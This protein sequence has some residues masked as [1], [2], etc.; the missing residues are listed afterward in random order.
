MNVLEFNG[1]QFNGENI[2]DI[3]YRNQKV[4]ECTFSSLEMKNCD[5][6]GTQFLETLFEQVTISGSDF[7]NCT[8]ASDQMEYDGNKFMDCSMKQAVIKYLSVRYGIFC[9]CN[10][11]GMS[12]NLGGFNECI[13]EKN[14]MKGF[15][16]DEGVFDC[17]KMI[18]NDARGANLAHGDFSYIEEMQDNDFS[19]S[20]LNAFNWYHCVCKSDNYSD[21]SMIH[22]TN[23]KTVFT[24][25][26]FKN[27]RIEKSYFTNVTFV[28]CEMDNAQLSGLEFEKCVFR[29]MDF[30]KFTYDRLQFKKCTFENV[31][32]TQEQ[33]RNFTCDPKIQAGHDYGKLFGKFLGCRWLEN[34][35][36]EDNTLEM[37]DNPDFVWAE[38]KD[39]AEEKIKSLKL[40]LLLLD[41]KDEMK[42]RVEELCPEILDE[43]IEKQQ[44]EFI[45]KKYIPKIREKVEKAVAGNALTEQTVPHI[46]GIVEELFI[47][48]FYSAY[49]KSDFYGA[50]LEVL[51][52]GHLPCGVRGKKQKMKI[53][54]Y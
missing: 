5:F 42:Y 9:G 49:F 35:G 14:N 24:N 11:E 23:E 51:L 46:T 22:T 21:C 37:L 33:E 41:V 25:C 6:S 29:D 31:K 15:R 26:N 45:R 44:R 27:A 28:N 20:H 34:W 12:V 32:M 43:D 4:E 17:K 16:I 40:S 47:Y 18:S 10:M 3:Q 7:D 30:T 54:I 48:D 52:S 36:V 8:F 39:D 2:T 38:G 50:M 1:K 53:V 13:F 19:G